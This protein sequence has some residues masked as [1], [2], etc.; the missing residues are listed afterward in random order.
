MVAVFRS[1]L[2]YFDQ[3]IASIESDNVWQN[4]QFYLNIQFEPCS[5][6]IR[7]I[8]FI[9]YLHFELD[10]YRDSTKHVKNVP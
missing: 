4:L 5:S 7:E 10:F 6:K 1:L 8:D 2:I 9:F 3:T